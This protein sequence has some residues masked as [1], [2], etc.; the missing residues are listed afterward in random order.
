MPSTTQGLATSREES[1]MEVVAHSPVEPIQHSE[2]QDALSLQKDQWAVLY[3]PDPPS[4]KY[5]LPRKM[6]PKVCVSAH[7]CICGV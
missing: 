3:S 1:V 4:M 5:L 6:L 2:A 7:M